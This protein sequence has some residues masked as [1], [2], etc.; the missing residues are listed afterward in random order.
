MHVDTC[1]MLYNVDKESAIVYSKLIDG[2][3]SV[4]NM[5]SLFATILQPVFEEWKTLHICYM[6]DENKV[7]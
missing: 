5:H 6:L 4:S 7:K 1:L 3:T 2:M